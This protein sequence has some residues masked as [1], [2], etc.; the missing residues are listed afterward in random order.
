MDEG[1]GQPSSS[2]EDV[3]EHRQ[4]PGPLGPLVHLWPG[5]SSEDKQEKQFDRHLKENKQQQQ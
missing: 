1:A 3:K 5:N 2:L 4:F